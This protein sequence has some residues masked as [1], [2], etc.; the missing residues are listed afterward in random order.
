MKDRENRL[1]HAQAGVRQDLPLYQ[2]ETFGSLRRAVH[3]Q[4]QH[5]GDGHGIADGSSGGRNG[6]EEANLPGLN[7]EIEQIATEK[8]E[9]LPQ[10]PALLK[11]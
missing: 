5:A 7:V 4:A 3:R 1:A 10:W 11:N 8:L 2:P 9:S 6:R